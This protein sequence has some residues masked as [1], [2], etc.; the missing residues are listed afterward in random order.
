MYKFLNNFMRGMIKLSYNTPKSQ[1][2]IDAFKGEGAYYTLKNLV[3][4]H[5]CVI[6]VNEKYDIGAGSSA[7]GYLKG[8][9]DA[10]KG[11][12]WR[13]FALM[14]KVIKDNNFNFNK[15]MNE[16]GVRGY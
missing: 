16:L 1:V 5:N 3:M 10:Y 12:G 6:N 9:L 8:A 4:Y 7:I 2:W 13:M 11:E 14:K 15:R